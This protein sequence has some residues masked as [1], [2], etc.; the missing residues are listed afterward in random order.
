MGSDHL[1]FVQLL[2]HSLSLLSLA[3]STVYGKLL[4][5]SQ[6]VYELRLFS[7]RSCTAFKDAHDRGMFADGDDKDSEGV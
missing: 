5:G 2:T 4:E 7:V 3:M 1:L 6:R